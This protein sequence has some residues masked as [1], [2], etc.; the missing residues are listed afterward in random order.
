MG[1]GVGK[2]GCV[3]KYGYVKKCNKMKCVN[4]KCRKEYDGEYV[5]MCYKG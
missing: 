5:C 3:N 2:E 4:G 1:Y